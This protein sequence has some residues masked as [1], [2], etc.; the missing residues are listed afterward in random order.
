MRNKNLARVAVPV[1][2]LA[3]AAIPADAH[4]A[5]HAPVPYP[6][7]L[8]DLLNDLVRYGDTATADSE[9]N[10]IST[11]DNHH[12]T[13]QWGRANIPT[14]SHVKVSNDASG[15]TFSHLQVTPDGE[16]TTT[17]GDTWFVGTARLTNST[18]Q[19]QS[20]TTQSYT[21]T[22]T[23]SVSTSVT[24]QFG[25]SNT[26]SA[27][28]KLGEFFTGG[29]EFTTTWT[30]GD[31]HTHTQTD[32]QTYTANAQQIA[33]PAHTT[34]VVTIALVQTKS[35][36][37]VNLKG[38]LDGSFQRVVTRTDCNDASGGCAPGHVVSN[39]TESV[40]DTALNAV[41]LPPGMYL[42]DHHTV[43]VPGLGTYTAAHGSYFT[44]KVTDEPDGSRPV[45]AAPRSYT[46]TLPVGKPAAH[47]G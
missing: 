32:D 9:K 27:Q 11:W 21:K 28:V 38:D 4:A 31:T 5:G 10:Y 15:V 37:L 7:S 6:A 33:V 34:A 14:T 29:D 43:A 39:K 25:G 23:D 22:V 44:V 12:W 40:Y 17:L 8:D 35:T 36:G 3:L 13:Y 18:D 46:Y 2:A 41:P 1:A 24:K 26:V 20:L 45:P 16:P 42:S 19:P 47:H 30:W